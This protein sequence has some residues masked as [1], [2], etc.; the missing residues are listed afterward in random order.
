MD[1]SFNVQTLTVGQLYNLPLF[2][3]LST[4]VCPIVTDINICTFIVVIC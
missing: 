4:S 3:V 2:V 1:V